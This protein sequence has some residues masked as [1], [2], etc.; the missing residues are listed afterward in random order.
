MGTYMTF[1]ECKNLHF[2][3]LII[4]GLKIMSYN[5]DLDLLTILYQ[6]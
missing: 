2:D 6:S 4:R 5:L 1:N 3:K